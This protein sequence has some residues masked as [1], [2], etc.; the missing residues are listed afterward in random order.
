MLD[1]LLAMRYTCQVQ[2]QQLMQ[3][4]SRQESVKRNLRNLTL[5]EFMCY[6]AES[7]VK[8]NWTDVAVHDKKIIN[9]MRP[10]DTRLWI[11]S[12]MGSNFLP[13][14]CKLYEKYKQEESEYDLSVVEVHMMRFLKNDRLGEMQS[15]IARAT[16]KFYFITK[17]FGKYDYSVTPASF[18]SVL[19]FVFSGKAN[20]FLN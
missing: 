2:S 20:Q 13:L 5:H 3:I 10:G 7:V 8:H 16:S 1:I 18:G 17:G 15:K 11:I 4:I 6:E 12:E 14:Y 19:D 9:K